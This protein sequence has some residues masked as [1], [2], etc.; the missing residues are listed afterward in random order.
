MRGQRLFLCDWDHK[1]EE[2]LGLLRENIGFGVFLVPFF[3][4]WAHRLAHLRPV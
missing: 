3:C 2:L 1:K 4:F